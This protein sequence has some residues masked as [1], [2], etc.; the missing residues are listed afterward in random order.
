MQGKNWH[1][2]KVGTRRGLFAQDTDMVLKYLSTCTHLYVDNASS[3]YA[4]KVADAAR[5][6][7]ETGQN[8]AVSNFV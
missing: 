7:S 6:S 3:L 2:I 8:V 4:L 1:T 5:R